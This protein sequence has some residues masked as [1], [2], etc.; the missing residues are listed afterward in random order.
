M[1]FWLGRIGGG[2][3]AGAIAFAIVFFLGIVENLLVATTIGLIAMAAVVAAGGPAVK[4]LGEV[5]SDLDW[6]A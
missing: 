2:V 1:A 6:W 4:A 5:L 3:V